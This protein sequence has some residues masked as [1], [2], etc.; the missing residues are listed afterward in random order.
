MFNNHAGINL[1]ESK[2]QLVE[3]GYKDDSF[4]LENVDQTIHTENFT[5]VLAEEKLI[6]ILQS[7]F[8]KIVKRKPFT[9]RNVSFALPNNFFKI[10]EVPYDDSLVKKDLNDHFRWEISVLFPHCDKDNFF[11]QYI[12]INKSSV[13]REKK[14][15]IFALDKNLVAAINKFCAQNSLEL[16]YIDN[17]HLASNAF[18]FL[19]KRQVNNDFTLSIYI[20]QRYSSISA[21]DGVSPFFF[22]NLD[23]DVH[24]IFDEMTSVVKKL[25]EYNLTIADF[26]TVLLFGQ[27]LTEEF[28]TKMKSYF[29]HALKKINPFE[30]LKTEENVLNNPLYK[31][32]FNSFAAATGIA[33]RMV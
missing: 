16:K 2:L 23:P 7:S 30:H 22:K 5:T 14:A 21:I 33:I 17:V 15:I 1:T 24:N 6:G 19:D 27:D 11:I 12:E 18:L 9:S 10:F 3:I 8:N 25:G 28:E 29:G 4:Y 26:K 32:K 13:C 31:I 20:D